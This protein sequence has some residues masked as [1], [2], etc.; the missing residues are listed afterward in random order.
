L[1]E[2]NE[3]LITEAEASIS[4]EEPSAGVEET[5]ISA[6]VL[7]APVSEPEVA[8]PSVPPLS[9]QES[10]GAEQFADEKLDMIADEIA[11]RV[12]E[13]FVPVLMQQLA[14]YFMQFPAIKRVVEDTSKQVVKELLPE[15]Q[16]KL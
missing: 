12:T 9:S 2:E 6:A 13:K 8:M 15:I 4:V 10:P 3:D 11:Q 1:V 16:D 7:E 5:P 14:R